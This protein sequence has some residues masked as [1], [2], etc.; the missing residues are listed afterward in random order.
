[1]KGYP[2]SSYGFLSSLQKLGY[3][4]AHVFELHISLVLEQFDA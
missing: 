4:L 3:L 2:N 1:V